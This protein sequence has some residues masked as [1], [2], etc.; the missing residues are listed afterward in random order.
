M[1]PGK[2]EEILEQPI[3]AR[4]SS[5]LLGVLIRQG[6]YEQE[7]PNLYLYDLNQGTYYGYLDLNKL[8]GVEVFR[9]PVDFVF[10][11]EK[12]KGAIAYSCKDRIFI[13]Y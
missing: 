4:F 6:I 13:L 12:T 11:E 3:L 1:A 7:A 5:S 9:E 10:L 8:T 2:A